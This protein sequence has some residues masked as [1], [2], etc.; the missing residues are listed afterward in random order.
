VGKGIDNGDHVSEA[1]ECDKYL[2]YSAISIKNLVNPINI[3]PPVI[4]I[5]INICCLL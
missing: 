2:E 4:I 5:D 1:A 3:R